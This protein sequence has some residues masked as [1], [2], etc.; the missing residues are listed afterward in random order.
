MRTTIPQAS[1]L[2]LEE[3]MAACLDAAQ[4]ETRDAVEIPALPP[5]GSGSEHDTIPVEKDPC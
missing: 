2:S 1:L 5:S 4:R 3:Y